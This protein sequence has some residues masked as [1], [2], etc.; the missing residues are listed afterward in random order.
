MSGVTVSEKLHELT[1][2]QTV[3]RGAGV[4]EVPR[5]E[6]TAEGDD[7]LAW[8]GEPGLKIEFPHPV[9][10]PDDLPPGLMHAL[11]QARERFHDV[12]W[13]GRLADPDEEEDPGAPVEQG[14]VVE[15]L[16]GWEFVDGAMVVTMDTDDRLAPPRA[17]DR[18]AILL[19]AALEPYG[20]AHVTGASESDHFPD[21]GD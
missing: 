1:C 14:P 18:M 3:L 16:G 17:I 10:G 13:D 6:P 12:R 5:G 4:V 7:V 20:P 2:R 9:H 21:G 19:V 15:S 11:D 8:F